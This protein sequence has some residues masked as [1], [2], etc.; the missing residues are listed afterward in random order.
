MGRQSKRKTEAYRAKFDKSRPER[1]G[2]IFAQVKDDK[3]LFR[4]QY[5]PWLAP[6]LY[7]Q[8]IKLLVH[9]I[10]EY[11]YDLQ[12]VEREGHWI[13]F[14]EVLELLQNDKE[15]LRKNGFELVE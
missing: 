13:T 15:W 14:H 7:S 12:L 2:R 4:L 8:K 3:L 1:I 9:R 11:G 10:N 6:H 5:E